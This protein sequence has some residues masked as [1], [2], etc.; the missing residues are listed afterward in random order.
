MQVDD[1]TK[2]ETDHLFALCRRYDLR[3]IVIQD[4]WDREIFPTTRSVEDL[5]ERY[6]TIYNLL[7]KART[8]NGQEP[9]IRYFDADHEKRRKEQLSKLYDRTSEQ[10]EEEQKLLEELRKIEMRKKE[11]EKKTQDLQKLITAADKN[12]N[13]KK[14]DSAAH[15]SSSGQRVFTF[16][17]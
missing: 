13:V 12:T 17:F 11:R 16:I 9:K 6:Y 7:S 15:K 10:V 3:F 4:R 2:A 5:K 8:P 1:W 14:A